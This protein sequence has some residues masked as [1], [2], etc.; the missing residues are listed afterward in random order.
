MNEDA[1]PA[2]SDALSAAL[3][4]MKLRAFINCTRQSAQHAGRWLRRRYVLSA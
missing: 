3:M 1:L 4:K 2:E